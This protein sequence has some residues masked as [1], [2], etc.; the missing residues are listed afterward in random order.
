MGISRSGG[1]L[2]TASFR[3]MM[4]GKERIISWKYHVEFMGACLIYFPGATSEETLAAQ[5]PFEV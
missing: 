2:E 1:T 4:V 5:Q 3:E